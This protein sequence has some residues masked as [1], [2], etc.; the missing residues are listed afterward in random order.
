[1][2]R[3]PTQPGWQP[4]T[5]TMV[6]GKR[7]IRATSIEQLETCYRALGGL[8]SQERETMRG[9]SPA[10]LSTRSARRPKSLDR[11]ESRQGKQK[12]CL[13]PFLRSS[14]RDG[15]NGEELGLHCLTLE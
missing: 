12:R 9:A 2:I 8:A 3:A 11:T 15:K 4:A 1:M 14:L 13:T 5:S 6:G 10:R 7:T